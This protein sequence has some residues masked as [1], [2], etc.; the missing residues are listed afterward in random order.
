MSAPI[1]TGT[2][3]NGKALFG[4][5][6]P[7]QTSGANSNG[8]VSNLAVT[9]SDVSITTVTV[10]T[11]ASGI[12]YAEFDPL[13]VGTAVATVT[14]TVTDPDGAKQDFTVTANIVVI[15]GVNDTLTASVEVL[16]SSTVPA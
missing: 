9:L 7:L 3:N 10:K 11:S 12:Q 8:V 16:F 5:I 6:Q 1:S 13:K 14:L 2:T 4:I 15:P